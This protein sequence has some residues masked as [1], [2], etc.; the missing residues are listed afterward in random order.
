MTLLEAIRARD[1]AAFEAALAEDPSAIHASDEHGVPA[2]RWAAYMGNP[3][4]AKRLASLGA[5]VDFFTACA[6]GDVLPAGEAVNRDPS[7]LFA[8]STD[9]WTGLHLAAFF[10]HEALASYLISRGADPRL[11]S[12]NNNENLPIHAAAAGKHAR[13]IALLIQANS[14]VDAR[15]EGGYTPLHSAAQNNDVESIRVLEA[16]GANWDARD[17]QGR[18]PRDLLPQA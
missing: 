10:G 1:E 13:L 3:G 14:P 8:H 18:T 11:R 16:A 12:T 9:G 15:Q 4:W 5:A 7:I 2:I 17:D 6:L